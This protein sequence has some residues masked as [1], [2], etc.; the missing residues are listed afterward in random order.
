MSNSPITLR[1]LRAEK[2]LKQ[3]TTGGKQQNNPRN[4]LT[5]YRTPG[6]L[7]PA[8]SLA[9]VPSRTILC[10]KTFS[11]RAVR[12]LKAASSAGQIL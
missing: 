4:V 3:K 1:K 7:F 5:A 9:L 2:A 11:D 10:T 12:P 8:E 6:M